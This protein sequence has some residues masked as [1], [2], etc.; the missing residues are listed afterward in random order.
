MKESTKELVLKL[1]M[2]YKINGSGDKDDVEK[3]EN[4]LF[5]D[6]H[7]DPDL[8]ELIE[9]AEKSE[10]F[11]DQYEVTQAKLSE[12]IGLQDLKGKSYYQT[13]G[14]CYENKLDSAMVY[15]AKQE[16]AKKE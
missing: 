6:P 2:E 10:K 5:E 8:I 15:I 16:L 1:Y 11:I 3:L 9:Y 13:V 14:D 12:R 7:S 4:M